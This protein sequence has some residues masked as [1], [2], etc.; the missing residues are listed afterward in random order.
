MNAVGGCRQSIRVDGR[1]G[2]EPTLRLVD[3]LQRQR[4][5]RACGEPV[6]DRRLAVGE[7]L[8]LLHREPA[9]G[10]RHHERLALVLEYAGLHREREQ[11][12]RVE[13]VE[14]ADQRLHERADVLQ[15]PPTVAGRAAAVTLRTCAD[16]RLILV[17]VRAHPPRIHD[18]IRADLHR[19]DRVLGRMP[20]GGDVRC[21]R[22]ERGL[23]QPARRAC[24]VREHTHWRAL[25]AVPVRAAPPHRARVRRVERRERDAR[26]LIGVPLRG[27]ARTKLRKVRVG[28]RALAARWT[29]LV[30]LHRAWRSLVRVAARA[31]P[32][33]GPEAARVDVGRS[34]RVL[35]HVPQRRELRIISDGCSHALVPSGDFYRPRLLAQ[36]LVVANRI[37][38]QLRSLG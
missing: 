25:K 27:E 1:R 21:E 18:V 30:I 20:L 36:A 38:P 26:V 23:L 4:I 7:L 16:R 28:V 35:P 31:A 33:G 11:L 8:Q 12:A 13:L 6:D 22:G 2:L 3:E 5:D 15:R 29:A 24:I 10:Q 17:P 14:M 34:L 32:H 37:R 19:C 9:V